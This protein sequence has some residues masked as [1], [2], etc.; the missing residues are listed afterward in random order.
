MKNTHNGQRKVRC[1]QTRIPELGYYLIITDTEETEKNY[2]D[3]LRDSL[4]EEIKNKIVITTITTDTKSLKYKVVEAQ[5]KQTGF[6]KTW[7]V[8][9]RDQNTEF[10]SLIT[11]IESLGASVGWS[12][13]CFE[14]WMN[15]YFGEMPSNTSSTAC[16]QGF[17]KVFKNKTKKE[18]KKSNKDIYKKLTQFG[19]ETKAI[20]IA[21]SKLKEASKKADLPSKMCPSTT[22]YRLVREVRNKSR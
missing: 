7:V 19:D 10:D 14:I 5:A 17:A 12:N 1:T 18:Y 4:P 11:E 20:S 13:P 15:A 9:D 2:F 3:G 8:F 21:E 22:V 16:C 6:R